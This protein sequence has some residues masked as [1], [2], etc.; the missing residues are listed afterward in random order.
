MRE[1]LVFIEYYLPGHKGGGALVSI[2][3][4]V[5]K[6]SSV[7]FKILTKDHDLGDN[8]FY[9][10]IKRGEW[11]T[12]GNSNVYYLSDKSMSFFKCQREIINLT[13]FD[14]YYFNSFFSILYTLYPLILRKVKKIPQKAAIIAP[15]NEFLSGVL[16]FKKWRK[17]IYIILFKLLKLHKGIVWQASNDLEKSSIQFVFKENAKIYIACNLVSSNLNS[18]DHVL[19]K[20][21][22]SGQLNIIF[23]SRLTRKKNLDYALTLLNSL[24]GNV[25]FEIYGPIEDKN[26]GINVRI[27][28]HL[29]Q[30][31]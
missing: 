10:N 25:K 9:P 17:K 16:V 19:E 31:I 8:E 26:I 3:N 4:M 13:T 2:S 29:Y 11:N 30:K 5:N 23:L 18:S 24:N 21:K 7:K 12:I 14:L 1:I 6:I 27:L 20:N 22:E 15:R 28:L